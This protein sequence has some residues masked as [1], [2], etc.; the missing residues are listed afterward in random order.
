L[1]RLLQY[2]PDVAPERR[3]A[4]AGRWLAHAAADLDM[5]TRGRLAAEALAVIA[6]PAF[7]H[8]FGPE[9]RAE[10]PIAGTVGSVAV[11]GQVDR[12]AVSSDSVF[13]LDYKTHR[14][15][16]ANESQVPEVYLRQMALY[17]A[18]LARAFPGRTVRCGLLWTEGPRIME[19]SDAALDRFAPEAR[20]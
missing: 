9:S 8:L 3:V 18:L 19:L 6:D 17:R 5:E 12:L 20:G 16:P 13:V 7:A 15:A 2:L 11:A 1:H 4:A 14:Q 10:V